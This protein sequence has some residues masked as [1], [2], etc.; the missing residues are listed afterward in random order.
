MA[1]IDIGN[2]RE[3]LVDDFLIDSMRNSRLR[4]A[5]PERRAGRQHRHCGTA[6]RKV[7]IA[8]G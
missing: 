8:D 6:V 7:E 4:L 5:R 2:G 3:S 1:P